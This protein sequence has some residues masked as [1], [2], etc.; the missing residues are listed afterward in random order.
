[1]GVAAEGR[2]I[3]RHRV[4]GGLLG[5]TVCSQVPWLPWDEIKVKRTL[6]FWLPRV[7]ASLRGTGA[8]GLWWQP[9]TTLWR[10]RE[11][12]LIQTSLRAREFDQGRLCSE[13]LYSPKISMLKLNPQG[14]G[15]RRWCLWGW[16]WS[17]YEAGASLQGTP[18]TAASP[19]PPCKD[20]MKSCICEP[21]SSPIRHRTSQHFNLGFPAF[22]T[23]RTKYWWFISHLDCGIL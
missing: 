9:G 21:E 15:V 6:E 7:K 13:C 2:E 16:G 4:K 12:T 11:E 18:Q 1:M 10:T 8:L 5:G 17:G 3:G 23:V 14:D 22:K 19:I 20:T